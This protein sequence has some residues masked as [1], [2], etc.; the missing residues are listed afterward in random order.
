MYFWDEPSEVMNAETESHLAYVLELRCLEMGSGMGAACSSR[1]VAFEGSRPADTAVSPG[2]GCKRPEQRPRITYNSLAYTAVIQSPF[3]FPALGIGVP[4]TW[5]CIGPARHTTP[6]SC[7]S[8]SATVGIRTRS[9][10][11]PLSRGVLEARHYP[12]LVLSPLG[13]EVAE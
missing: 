8:W 2:D 11:V 9:T 4:T 13:R 10:S 5:G 1:E 6:T 7:R 3:R 12:E